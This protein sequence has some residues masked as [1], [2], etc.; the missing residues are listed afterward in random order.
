M[1]YPRV[2]EI[3]KAYSGFG[4][5]PA[6][7]LQ[8]AASRGTKVH[9]LC[10]GV[11]KGAWIP[12]ESIEEE[13]AGY[14]NSFRQW[15]EAI[16]DE[17]IFVEKRFLDEQLGYTG[18]IDFVIKGKDEK[19][20]L[21]DLKTS[22]KPQKTYVIQMAAYKNLLA[23]HGVEIKSTMLVYLDKTGEKPKIHK[24]IGLEKEFTVFTSALICWRYFH[25]KQS[26]KL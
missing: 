16:P 8:R 5:V 4:E 20:H 23:K 2:T 11:A 9:A 17:Y 7:I 14:V 21:V 12:E 6:N 22:S 10:A 25:G 15:H 26:S 1:N 3:L 18:Q 19:L 24:H 13:Y